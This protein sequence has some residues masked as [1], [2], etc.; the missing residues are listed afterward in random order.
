[1]PTDA[2]VKI[3]G[4]EDLNRALRE[5]GITATKGKKQVALGAAGII[6]DE[7]EANAPEEDGF[8]KAHIIQEILEE[9]EDAITV[10]VGPDRDAFY[11][12]IVEFG[13]DPHNEEPETKRVLSDGKEV[14]GVEVNH[15]GVPERPFLRPAFD[16]NIDR[17]IAE[18]AAQVKKVLKL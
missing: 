4:T 10:A 18:A 5:L 1:M 15:P 11:G 13:A 17:A 2:S 7:A 12:L 8:L 16:D 9:T 14:F 3:L 6:R